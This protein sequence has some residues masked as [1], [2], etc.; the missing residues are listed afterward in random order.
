M[1][2]VDQV[3]MVAGILTASEAIPQVIKILKTKSAL[4]LSWGSLWITSVCMST[5]VV[6]GLL[7]QDKWVTFTCSVCIVE[8]ICIMFWKAYFDNK[9]KKE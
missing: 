4:D 5:W 6:Y 1:H 9:K 8:Y 3:G 2:I 7:S